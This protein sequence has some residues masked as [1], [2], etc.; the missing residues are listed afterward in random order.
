MTHRDRIYFLS[1]NCR[2]FVSQTFLPSLNG[3]FTMAFFFPRRDKHFTIDPLNVFA[4]L[5]ERCLKFSHFFARS[6]AFFQPQNRCHKKLAYNK[7]HPY[8]RKMPKCL[9]DIAN[10]QTQHKHPAKNEA[11]FGT[12]ACVVA[13]FI[14]QSISFASG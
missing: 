10:W 4:S 9:P 12:G 2:D 11:F 3:R 6:L 1:P 5:E 14:M 13:I 7:S 8:S